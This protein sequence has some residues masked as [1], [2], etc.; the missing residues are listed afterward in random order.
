[1]PSARAQAT[2]SHSRKRK[3]TQRTQYPQRS[4]K[5]DV[6]DTCQCPCAWKCTYV[7]CSSRA[8][9]AECVPGPPPHGTHSRQRRCDCRFPGHSTRTH[10][11]HPDVRRKRSCTYESRAYYVRIIQRFLRAAEQTC[12]LPAVR[13]LPVRGKVEQFLAHADRVAR[14]SGELA[15]K[16]SRRYFLGLQMPPPDAASGAP[17]GIPGK[18]ARV[19][20]P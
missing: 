7:A 8:P 15:R 14:P 9:R 19:A 12:T 6:Q 10:G 11:V 5:S 3:L 13:L 1:M 20:A 2:A 18:R 17:R 16:E 4:G